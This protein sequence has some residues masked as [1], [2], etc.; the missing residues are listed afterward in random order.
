MTQLDKNLSEV[1][2]VVPMSE[3]SKPTTD[4]VTQTTDVTPIAN[5]PTANPQDVADQKQAEDD[6]QTV[7]KNMLDLLD[8]GKIAVEAALDV[9]NQTDA[10]RAFEVFATL[11]GTMGK[12]N[13]DLEELH[14]RK[15][16]LKN[17]RAENGIPD[18]VV[19]NNAIF[20]GS[21]AELSK[22]LGK[23]NKDSK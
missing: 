11:I 19:N 17:R 12:M 22:M 6:F 21:T 7:R 14:R 18:K 15:Q 8:K 13:I 23:M 4:I 20:V 10:P 9:V 2:D 3:T 5:V 1:F 16:D